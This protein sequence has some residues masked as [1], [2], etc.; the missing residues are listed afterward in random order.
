MGEGNL[1]ILVD[2]GRSR[3]LTFKEFFI[4]TPLRIRAFIRIFIIK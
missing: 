4:N 1:R 3:K 2:W